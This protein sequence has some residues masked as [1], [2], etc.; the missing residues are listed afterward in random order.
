MS[1]PSSFFYLL[2]FN[3]K[4]KRYQLSAGGIAALLWTLLLTGCSIQAPDLVLLDRKTVLEEQASGELLP[5]EDALREAAIVPQGSYFTRGQLEEAGADLSHDALGRLTQIYQAPV[6]ESEYLDN[7]LV[8]RCIGEARSGLLVETA[9]TCTGRTNASRTSA[10]VQRTNR[11]R[12]QLWRY[13]QER[14]PEATEAQI[15][16]LWRQRHLSAVVCGGQIQDENGG[17]ERK[18]C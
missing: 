15:R 9:N 17:W 7:L 13:L 11:S 10:A 8:Q 1:I 5:L 6:T 12:K 18:Q 14:H 2:G 3:L 4:G 16:H